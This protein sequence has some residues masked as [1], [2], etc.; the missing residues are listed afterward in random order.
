MN[1]IDARID[2]ELGTAVR[3]YGHNVEPAD[4]LGAIRRATAE[5]PARSWQ[6]WVLAGG[7]AVVAASVVMGTLLLTGPSETKDAPVAATA[8]TTVYKVEQ[9]GEN[10]WLL[11]ERVDAADS[12]D[13]VADAVGALIA[14]TDAGQ[15][16]DRWIGCS[17]GHLDA[18]VVAADMVTVTLA[19]SQ[20]PCEVDPGA[21]EAQ[22]QQ[23]AWTVREAVGTDLPVVLARDGEPI[24]P[25]PIVADPAALSPVLID[26]PADGSTVTSPVA[27]RGTSD[28]FEANVPWQVLQDDEIVANGST[29]GGS[30][31]ERR[32][33]RDTVELPPGEY[34]LRVWEDSA[35]DG[36]L[37]AEDTVTFTVE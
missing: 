17:W 33:W 26:E 35:Q 5:R 12:G 29:M 7:A 27:L 34:M 20:A 8:S 10:F 36:S 25:Q 19:G 14:D 6:P 15:A 9:V 13:E 18:V 30:Y 23:L 24:T 22:F 28:T 3:E 31:G 16:D 37:R 11:P 4:R 2:A 32:P 21:E 1:E